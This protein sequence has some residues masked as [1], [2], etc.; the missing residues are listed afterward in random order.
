MRRHFTS[1]E[2]FPKPNSSVTNHEKTPDNLTLVTFYRLP[3][4]DSY[5][6]Q[7]HEKQSKTEKLSQTK[8]RRLDYEVQCSGILG[9]KEDI[10]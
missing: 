4:W 7:G 9:Q 5:N 2:F 8:R 6:N 3:G 10:N 1:G